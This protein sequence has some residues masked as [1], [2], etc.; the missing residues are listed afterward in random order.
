MTTTAQDATA[1][2]SQDLGLRF[3][4]STFKFAIG[5]AV[6]FRK[7]IKVMAGRFTPRTF[8]RSVDPE[9]LWAN[10]PPE[11][12]GVMLGGFPV[13]RPL[14]R[15]TWQKHWI[16]YVP[17]HYRHCSV[18]LEGTFQEYLERRFSPK[19]RRDLRRRTRVLAERNG[20]ELGLVVCRTPEEMTHFMDVAP[21]LAKRTYQHTLFKNAL[22]DTPEYRQWV[23]DLAGQDQARGYL[24]RCDGQV[25]AYLFCRWQDGMWLYDGVGYDQCFA[26]LS[27]GT[28]LHYH[29]LDALFA[30]G[31]G[32]TLDFGPGEGQHKLFFATHTQLCADVYL[33]R[34]WIR[35]H[36]LTWT[37]IG[38]DALSD[39]A[40]RVAGRLGVRQGIK[41]LMRR[42]AT[43]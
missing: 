20:G 38:S 34:P 29:A 1:L 36:L 4:T 27:P 11:A 3:K 22:P 16:R 17:R 25:I 35:N 32:G 31:R 21:A 19:I 14:E 12:A 41:R 15:M 42:L 33:L 40:A 10:V 5:E 28:L 23:L 7:R 24:L 9:A 39:A 2:D 6:L 13:E 26:R 18:S 30:E 43:G 37:H 8:G